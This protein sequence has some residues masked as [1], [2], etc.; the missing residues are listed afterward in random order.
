MGNREFTILNDG[1]DTKKM[2]HVVRLVNECEQILTEGDIDLQRSREQLKSVRRGEWSLQNIEEFFAIKE[3]SLEALYASSELQHSPD[4][5]KI[6][7]LL[8][9]CLEQHYGSLE[10]AVNRDVEVDSLIRDMQDVLD[11]Y[12]K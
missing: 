10:G 4:E 8:L 11:K 12:Q 7:Q 9:D 1:I 6:K 5:G 2:Y 3:R